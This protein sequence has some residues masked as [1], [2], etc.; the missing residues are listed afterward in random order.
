MYHPMG[1]APVTEF[2]VLGRSAGRIPS[3]SFKGGNWHTLEAEMLSPEVVPPGSFV[4]AP[5]PDSPVERP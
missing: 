5:S 3:A 4:T 2:P 1:P